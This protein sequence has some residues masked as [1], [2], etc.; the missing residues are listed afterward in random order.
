M[1]QPQTQIPDP[2][3]GRYGGQPG[4]PG[5]QGGYPGGGRPDVYGGRRGGYGGTGP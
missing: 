2:R 5:F 1:P 4:G 3:G